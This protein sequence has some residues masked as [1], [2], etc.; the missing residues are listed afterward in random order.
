[1]AADMNRPPPQSYWDYLK[2]ASKYTGCDPLDFDKTIALFQPYVAGLFPALPVLV[3][4]LD[5]SQKQY[6][7]MS[8]SSRF[9]LGYPAEYVMDGG[10]EFICRQYKVEDFRVYS[11]KIFVQN[12]HILRQL[13][14]ADHSRLIFGNKYRFLKR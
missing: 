12:L 5:F 8:Q 14:A 10:L 9:V 2:V 6:L 1:M 11:E 4:L 3:F 7:F 13:P